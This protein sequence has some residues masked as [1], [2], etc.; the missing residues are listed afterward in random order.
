MSKAQIKPEVFRAHCARAALAVPKDE[1]DSRNNFVPYFEHAERDYERL[2]DTRSAIED[3]GVRLHGFDNTLPAESGNLD[4]GY[5]TKAL[6]GDD[7]AKILLAP[8]NRF[9]RNFRRGTTFV[10]VMDLSPWM[11]RPKRHTQKDRT[12]QLNKTL[13]RKNIAPLR[14]PASGAMPTI[15]AEGK[16]LPPWPAVRANRTLYRHATAQLLALVERTYKPPPGRRLIIDCVD[17]AITS[18]CDLDAWMRTERVEC[19]D[20]ARGVVERARAALRGRADWRTKVRDIVNVLGHGNHM[21][22]VPVCIETNSD[23]LTYAPFLLRNVVKTCGEADIGILYWVHALSAARLH[24]TLHGERRLVDELPSRASELGD[25]YTEAQRAEH[26]AQKAAL[27]GADA[28]APQPQPFAEQCRDAQRLLDAIDAARNDVTANQSLSDGAARRAGD[29]SARAHLAHAL[30]GEQRSADTLDLVPN[31]ALVFSSDT[32]FL[33]L[34]TAHHAQALAD[35]HDAALR[36]G[37]DPQRAHQRVVCNAPLLSIGECRVLRCGALTSAEDYYVLPSKAKRD[38]AARARAKL[39][40]EQRAA[41]PPE[42]QWTTALEVWDI[43]RVWDCVFD[44]LRSSYQERAEREQRDDEAANDGDGNEAQRILDAAST[45]ALFC[46]SCQNDYL[47]GLGGVNRTD[48]FAGLLAL[49]APLVA[50]DKARRMPIIDPTRYA[51]YIKHCYHRSLAA[52]RG[53]ANKPPRAAHLMSYEQVAAVVRQKYKTSDKSHMPTRARLAL[54]YQR[55]QWWI[56][57]AMSGWRGID[58]LLDD[59]VWGWP[60]G[61]TDVWV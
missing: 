12:A 42:P 44:K 41:M 33:S 60:E 36:D 45:F 9:F 49:G 14:V 59:T 10:M 37:T 8:V 31:R 7:L 47:A 11:P 18:P 27:G 56:V 61:S 52:K 29:Q 15:V 26:A 2:D 32:D 22:S 50:Y 25:F 20:Y 55:S 16:V 53:K 46:A 5:T 30:L 34:L 13:E 48:M 23:G 3:S 51:N 58:A 54:M 21:R 17:T 28:L 4:A 43:A 6:T 35:A 40:P 39:T 19:D 24:H 38:A 1:T 57:Y